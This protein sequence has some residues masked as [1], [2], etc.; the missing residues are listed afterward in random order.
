MAR[1]IK[2]DFI[3]VTTLK[4]KLPFFKIYVKHNEDVPVVIAL[5]L[6]TDGVI[7]IF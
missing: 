6:V 2:N 4:Y 7:S 3:I 5:V 1:L